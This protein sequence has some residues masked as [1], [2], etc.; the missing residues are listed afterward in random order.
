MKTKK[1]KSMSLEKYRLRFPLDIP[2]KCREEKMEEVL[3][4][5]KFS[6]NCFVM[7]DRFDG[8]MDLLFTGLNEDTLAT[9]VVL[10]CKHPQLF[11]FLKM[12]LITTERLNKNH[13]SGMDFYDKA[14]KYCKENFSDLVPEDERE[15]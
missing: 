7:F 8:S 2:E 14:L 1:I 3:E 10:M 6:R 12:A 11:Q 13:K 4:D 9:F 5:I 15:I